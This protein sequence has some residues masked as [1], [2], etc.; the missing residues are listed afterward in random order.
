MSHFVRFL[1]ME[2]GSSCLYSKPLH[3]VS[4]DQQLKDSFIF[5]PYSSV[6]IALV[7][8]QW[9]LNWRQNSQ[10]FWSLS[11]SWRLLRVSRTVTSASETFMDPQRSLFP[12]LSMLP[13]ISIGNNFKLWLCL[14][15]QFDDFYFNKYLR[16]IR[17]NYTYSY[18]VML[19]YMYEYFFLKL[20]RVRKAP[21]FLT[22]L[23][24]TFQLAF[25]KLLCG[26][27]CYYFKKS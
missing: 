14:D 27:K 9:P 2:L 5:F 24:P 12:G 15:F 6:P 19:Q 26:G 18:S 25:L 1:G 10:V 20:F 13:Y 7:Q 22:W 8:L 17:N 16:H 21:R 11:L 23:C 3:K 4:E